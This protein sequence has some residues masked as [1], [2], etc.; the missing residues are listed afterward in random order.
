[1]FKEINGKK[2]KCCDWCEN[3]FEPG[4]DVNV[5]Q[6]YG[7]GEFCNECITLND[8]CP[9]CS[10]RTVLLEEIQETIGIDEQVKDF[11]EKGGE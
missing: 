3:V 9:I 10:G 4:M 11:K 2:V 5:C 1:M 8:R 6:K 7:C